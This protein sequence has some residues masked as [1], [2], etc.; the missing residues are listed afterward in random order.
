MAAEQRTP[1]SQA[2]V[3]VAFVDTVTGCRFTV[4]ATRRSGVVARLDSF[5]STEPFRAFTWREW[6]NRCRVIAGADHA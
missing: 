2:R 4:T 5:A 3:G 6:F 1:G